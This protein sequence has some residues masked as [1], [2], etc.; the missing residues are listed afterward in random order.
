MEAGAAARASSTLAEHGGARIGV[1]T[2]TPAGT[3]VSLYR[4]GKLR[5]QL[6]TLSR[7]QDALAE[8]EAGRIDATLLPLDRLDAWRLAHP[9]TPL[10][11]AA[12]LHPLRIN[13]GFVARSD[14]SALLTVA[15]R[16]IERSLAGGDLLGE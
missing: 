13:F 10:R 1:V 15:D 4:N 16:V 14:A 9:S 6:V 8:L 5:P 7:Q 12:C 11:R 3:V 2:G